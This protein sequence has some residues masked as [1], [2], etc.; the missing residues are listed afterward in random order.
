MSTI[1]LVYYRLPFNS[2]IKL[3]KIMY[4]WTH[5]VVVKHIFTTRQ[6]VHGLPECSILGRLRVETATVTVEKRER[7]CGTE[8]SLS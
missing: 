3:S 5:S 6:A 7:A 8:R 1:L 4:H 2:N